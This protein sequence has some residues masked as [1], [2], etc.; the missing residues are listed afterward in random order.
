MQQI[1]DLLWSK[2]EESYEAQ[3]CEC[4]EEAVRY[5]REASCYKK[6]LHSSEQKICDLER[7]IT[8]LEDQQL[9]SY[10]R[11]VQQVNTVADQADRRMLAKG[12][13]APEWVRKLYHAERVRQLEIEL[14]YER[15]Y[16]GEHEIAIRE[17]EAEALRFQK[18]ASKIR[19]KAATIQKMPNLHLQIKQLYYEDQARKCDEKAFSFQMKE[20][21]LR[22]GVLETETWIRKWDYQVWMGYLKDPQPAPFWQE[23]KRVVSGG[24]P[25]IEA[26]TLA[27][28]ESPAEWAARKGH[29]EDIQSRKRTDITKW[30]RWIL[31]K[32]DKLCEYQDQVRQWQEK[33]LQ[34]R[35]EASALIFEPTSDIELSNRS[36]RAAL[37]DSGKR[38]HYQTIA[39]NT[40]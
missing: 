2:I 12:E 8:E 1:I 39:S 22:S 15:F 7:Q 31:E 18:R 34:F 6:L 29:D 16:A 21:S 25:P 35:N 20:S 30:D 37:L 23:V 10:E 9:D 27:R 4:D 11:E 24:N 3:A 13:P 32:A 28:L 40:I 19:N 17:Y 38:N 26:K 14:N 36:E 5:Q 33:A